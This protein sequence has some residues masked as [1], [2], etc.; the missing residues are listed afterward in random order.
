MLALLLA[1]SSVLPVLN[2]DPSWGRPV[3]P[4][5]VLALASTVPVAWRSRY[6]LLH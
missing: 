6:P 2:G 4:G 5:L 3:P 1:V